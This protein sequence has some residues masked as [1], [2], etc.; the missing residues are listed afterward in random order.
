VG[1]TTGLT[2]NPRSRNSLASACG[3]GVINPKIG[4]G[5]SGGKSLFPDGKGGPKVFGNRS[6]EGE[7]EA[8][9]GP[10]RLYR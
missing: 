7:V 4:D 5:G 8:S 1:G 10:S 9:R 3:S 6:T 2:M